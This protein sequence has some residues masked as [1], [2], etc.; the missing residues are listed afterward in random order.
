[1]GMTA[2]IEAQPARL[3]RAVRAVCAESCA[4]RG[5][6]PCWQ[7]CPDEWPN[8]NCDEPGCKWLALRAIAAWEALPAKGAWV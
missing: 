6:P 1:M 5:E 3:D 8:P 7:I 2:D 4:H